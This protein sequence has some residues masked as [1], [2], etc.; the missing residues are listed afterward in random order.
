MFVN[1]GPTLKPISWAFSFLFCKKITC[2]VRIRAWYS[3]VLVQI[4][5]VKCTLDIIL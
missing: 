1:T 3:K 4:I 5:F 2:K